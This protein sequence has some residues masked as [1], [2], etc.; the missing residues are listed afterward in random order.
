MEYAVRASTGQEPALA[1][2]FRVPAPNWVE[3]LDNGSIA[4][5]LAREAE[6][7]KPPVNRALRKAARAALSMV[8]GNFPNGIG[9]PF[10]D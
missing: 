6:S 5:L 1:L 8:A 2:L 7:A 3:M 9:R 10:L 4:E